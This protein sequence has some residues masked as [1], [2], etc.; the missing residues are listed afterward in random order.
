M[1]Q[2]NHNFLFRGK[3][4]KVGQVLPDD[5]CAVRYRSQFVDKIP[6]EGVAAAELEKVPVGEVEP[7]VEPKIAPTEPVERVEVAVTPVT[8]TP[9][10]APV[11]NKVAPVVN[12]VAPVVNKVAPVV[13]KVAPTPAANRPASTQ[14]NSAARPAVNKTTGR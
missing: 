14:T 11:V 13:N 6:V 10:P 9:A 12:K 1:H 7:S 4:H 3:R 5:H 8:I 2:V